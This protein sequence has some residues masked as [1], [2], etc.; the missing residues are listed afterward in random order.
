MFSVQNPLG[1]SET[2]MHYMQRNLFNVFLFSD[3]LQSQESHGGVG[4]KFHQQT[5]AQ[6]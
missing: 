1:M 3:C 6:V 4:L 2:P 5:Q